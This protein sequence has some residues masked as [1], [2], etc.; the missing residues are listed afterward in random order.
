MACSSINTEFVQIED[1]IKKDDSFGYIETNKDIYEKIV[2]D[3]YEWYKTYEGEPHTLKKT[4]NKRFNSFIQKY[5]I[6]CKKSLLIYTYKQMIQDKKI[7]SDQTMWLL[8]Q[9]KPS[10]NLSGISVVTVLTAP[11][12]DGQR[13]SCKHNCYYC[14][15][16]PG[17][18]RSY[19][20]KEPAVARANDNDFDAERQMRDRLDTL[21]MNGHEIDKLEIIIEG[22]TFTE[23]P[24][25]Y[26]NYFIRDLIWTANVYS[27]DNPREKLSIKEEIEINATTK[28][29]IIGICIETRPDSFLDNME[30]VR[31]LRKWGVTRIQLGLQHL[32][33]EILRKVNRG[34]TVED[35]KK[36]IKLLKN[37]CY[38]IDVH[39]MPDLP[40]SSPEKDAEMF[41]ELYESSE[42]QPD[43]IK[44]YPCEVVPW[45][46]IQKWHKDGTYTPYAQTN[47]RALLDVVKKAMVDCPPWIRL[48]RVIRDIPLT[49]IEGGNMYPNLRQMLM[50]EIEKEGKVSRDIRVRECGRNPGYDYKDANYKSYKY[51]ASDGYEYFICLESEDCKCLFGFL[52]LRIPVVKYEPVIFEC[53]KDAALIRELHVYGNLIPVGFNK[54]KDSQH[55][56]I[57][58]QLLKIAEHI[59]RKHK[60][61]K[62]A[63]ISGIGVTK[64]Y[65]K[66]GYIMKD[67]FMVKDLRFKEP[68]MI[69]LYFLVVI[70]TCFVFYI[71]N[72]WKM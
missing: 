34:H 30:W 68:N 29:R 14:P 11:F 41:E 9:K 6:M 22:G 67:T 42:I 38:K 5:R 15:A 13:F 12:P 64:Y 49:Y 37:N 3:I 56:G 72:Y 21:A 1:L 17:Q 57:G 46:V 60:Y 27:D 2:Y 43:Q 62:I 51:K 39:I 31:R 45:T 10:R 71:N 58:T 18:P 20:K 55:K 59:A 23:Y 16:E 44:I 24:I 19:L 4:F 69:M 26:L 7:E 50:D 52:R 63:V 54:K 40:G 8:L 47:E 35:A 65:E 25:F 48:P 53:L 61:N 70:V 36:A 66:K 28:V 33:D 32:D